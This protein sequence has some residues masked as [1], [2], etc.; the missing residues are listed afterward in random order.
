MLQR[1]VEQTLDESCVPRER[2]QQRT[3]TQIDD[4]AQELDTLL[5]Q[6]SIL[7]VNIASLERDA[8]CGKNVAEMEW[9]DL[10][11]FLKNQLTEI[12]EQFVLL[13]RRQDA[14]LRSLR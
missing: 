9:A 6:H 8:E 14:L 5:K 1:T 2:V 7:L 11:R 10:M 4:F 13:V 3:A 12:D